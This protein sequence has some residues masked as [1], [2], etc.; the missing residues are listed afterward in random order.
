MGTIPASSTLYSIEPPHLHKK[1]S[2]MTNFVYSHSKARFE[3]SGLNYY[4][5]LT[6]T[7]HSNLL[8]SLPLP[9]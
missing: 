9:R 4:F 5:F 3:L 1:D 8:Y 7:E 2:H 6:F